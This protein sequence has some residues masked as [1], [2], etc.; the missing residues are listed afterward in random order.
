MHQDERAHQ[1]ERGLKSTMYQGQH[2]RLHQGQQ[3]GLKQ[4]DQQQGLKR[5]IYQDQQRGPNQILRLQVLLNYDDVLC[6][7]RVDTRT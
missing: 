4:L 5:I 6:L 2:Q 1:D 3:Q 7:L